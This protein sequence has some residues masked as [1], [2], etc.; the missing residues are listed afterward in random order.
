MK[1]RKYRN[2]HDHIAVITRRKLFSLICFENQS[3]EMQGT[4]NQHIL[5]SKMI[6]QRLFKTSE[7]SHLKMNA[8]KINDP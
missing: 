2:V 3:F 8:N 4:D 7:L 5:S 1:R 6:D